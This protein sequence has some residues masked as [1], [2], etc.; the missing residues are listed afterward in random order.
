[1]A[2]CCAGCGPARPRPTASSIERHVAAARRLARSLV[3]APADADDIVAEVFAATFAAIRRGQRTDEDFR[4][5]RAALGAPRVP[6]VVA[7]RRTSRSLALDVAERSADPSDDFARRDER[8]LLRA[9]VRRR[10]RRGCRP[11]C[12]SIEVEGLSHAEIARRTR[13]TP[14]AIGQLAVRARRALGRA[15]P[16]GPP[17]GHGRPPTCRSPCATARASLAELVRGTANAA[18]DGRSTDAPRRC[19]ACAEAHDDL[20]VVNERLRGLTL[21][22]VATTVAVPKRWVGEHGDADR[23]AGARLDGTT[24]RSGDDRRRHRRTVGGAR[25]VGAPASPRRCRCVVD[26]SPARRRR[27]TAPSAARRR[28]AGPADDAASATVDGRD[29]R[30]GPAVARPTGA[31]PASPPSP[32]RRRPPAGTDAHRRRPRRPSAD[33]RRVDRRATV[34]VPALRLP[35]LPPLPL[36]G[37]VSDVARRR[38]RWR[39]TSTV[40]DTVEADVSVGGAT[41]GPTGSDGVDVD[42]G[43]SVDVPI[44]DAAPIDGAARRGADRGAT[45]GPPIARAGRT[46][47][48]RRDFSGAGRHVRA[49]ADCAW[50]AGTRPTCRPGART[51]RRRVGSP[52]RCPSAADGVTSAPMTRIDLLLLT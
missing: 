34:D 18:G 35:A 37:Q 10:C 6:A 33:T 20:C 23:L 28:R 36:V 17:G 49:A 47:P 41:V 42:V 7:S 48:R 16:P 26:S 5:V 19:A 22:A 44:V 46:C 39:S 1:M 29:R 3:D 4:A 52:R 31:S 24:H 43:G 8:E 15:L 50:G 14:Q 45:R 32:R 38:R 2:R 12:G 11:C 25:G 40:D 21:L 51:P 30:A 9:G 13:S 27:V